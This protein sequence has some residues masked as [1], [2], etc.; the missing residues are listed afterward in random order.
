MNI[1]FIGA[2]P[3]VSGGVATFG[4]NLKKIFKKDITFIAMY[5]QKALYNV[6]SVYE[7]L[8]LNLLTRIFNK[9]F[10]KQIWSFFLKKNKIASFDTCIINKPTSLNYLNFKGKIILVQHQTSEQY[11]KRRDYL[12]KSKKLLEKLKNNIDVFVTLSPYDREDFISRFNLNKDKVT[13]I[14][15]SSE[16]EL[17]KTDKV[18]SKNLLMVCRLDNHHKRLDLAIEAMIKLPDYILNIYGDG[19][20]RKMLEG[21]KEKLNLKNVIFHGSTNKVQD[22]LDENGIFVMTSDYEGYGI[23]LIEAMRRGLPI[24]LRN[25]YTSSSDIVQGN[26]V[27]LEKKWNEEE[28][29][30]GIHYIHH[31]YEEFSKESLGL[32]KRHDLS[33]VSR[34]WK[35]LMSR[36]QTKNSEK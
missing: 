30:K 25:T 20:D 14:R 26:G 21:M 7:C 1:L 6:D 34:E 2:N 18:K 29:V 5:K 16:I 12:Y 27:M 24:I 36:L 19:P 15:H 8:P 4:R 35:E 32:G 3:K 10:I 9:I 31:N 13:F 28:F 17:L 11:W 23:T 33:I 22:K